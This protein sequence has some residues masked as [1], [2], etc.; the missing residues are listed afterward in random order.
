MYVCE[1]DTCLKIEHFCF[2]N[3]LWSNH[4]SS[5]SYICVP[6]DCRPDKVHGGEKE[7][8]CLFSVNI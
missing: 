5:D 4:L 3:S 8:E 2:A 6:G 1:E 7:D